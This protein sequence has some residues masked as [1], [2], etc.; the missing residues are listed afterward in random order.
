M[1]DLT[2]ISKYDHLDYDQLVDCMRVCT[3]CELS[4][5]RHKVVVGAG[6]TPCSLMIIG[7]APGKDEDMQGEPFVGRSG[8]LLTKILESVGI[9]RGRD[10]FIANTIKCRPPGNRDPQLIE[11][12]ACRGYL[13]RQLNVV[14][15]KVLILLGNPALKTILGTEHAI[16]KVRGNWFQARVSYS[17]TPLYIM[18]IFHPSYLLRNQSKDKG[19]PKWLTWQDIREVKTAL[20][21]YKEE[22]RDVDAVYRLENKV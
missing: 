9:I 2:E 8:Q 15:P 1:L 6:P 21:F 20:D 11:L 17:K 22:A 16:T 3:R 12:K 14:Q 5:S 18:P 13:M 4:K 7:E 10:V 19:S